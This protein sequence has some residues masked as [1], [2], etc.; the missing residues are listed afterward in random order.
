MF[1]RF[2]CTTETTGSGAD[3]EFSRDRSLCGLSMFDGEE[4]DESLDRLP[5]R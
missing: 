1:R 5:W 4:L 3:D 2:S